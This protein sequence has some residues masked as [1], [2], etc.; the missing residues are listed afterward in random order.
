MLGYYNR[1]VILTYIGLICALVGCRC[2]MVGETFAAL[3]CL[4]ICGV[5]DMFDGTIARATKRSAEEKV[6]GIQI[7]S[8]CDLVSFGILPAILLLSVYHSTLSIIV[9]SLFVLAA[10][11]R[12]AFFNVHEQ[13]RQQ[14]SDGDKTGSRGLPVTFS[15]W[16]IP[17]AF[18]FRP[19]SFKWFPLFL[20]AVML[21]TAIA[22]V[23]DFHLKK[24]KNKPLL[25]GA[26]CLW[27]ILLGIGLYFQWMN[28]WPI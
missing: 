23:V 26:G 3:L 9:A 8:L 1:S 4:L 15:A 19:L 22:F 10:V 5:C 25:Y 7:D 6:F 20:A 27:L 24:P 18:L 12:L 14:T 16:I 13:I 2:A 11:I 21:L 17:T 28:F